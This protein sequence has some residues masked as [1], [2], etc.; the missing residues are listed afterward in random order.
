MLQLSHYFFNYTTG[1][2]KSYIKDKFFAAKYNLKVLV[3]L[4]VTC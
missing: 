3:I 4:L 1:I 2:F